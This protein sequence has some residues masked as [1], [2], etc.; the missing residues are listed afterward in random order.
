MTKL[1]RSTAATERSVLRTTGQSVDDLDGV[2]M[3][4][5]AGDVTERDAG[6]AVV[7]QPTLPAEFSP[8]P[9]SAGQY[10][11]KKPGTQINEE[12]NQQVATAGTTAQP[13]FTSTDQT[14]FFTTAIETTTALATTM[15]SSIATTQP[16][17]SPPTSHPTTVETTSS[18]ETTTI[19]QSEDSSTV[20]PLNIAKP[21]IRFMF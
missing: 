7:T 18:I 2:A 11:G 17:E 19:N 21:S 10:D 8:Q 16:T 12:R 1:E 5:E 13:S 4:E 3:K 14:E 15:E 20:L 6:G 9:H